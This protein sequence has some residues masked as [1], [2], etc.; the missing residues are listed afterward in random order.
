MKNS[1]PFSRAM[2]AVGLLALTVPLARA[3]RAADEDSIAATTERTEKEVSGNYLQKEIVGIKPQAGFVTFKNSD[4]NTDSRLAMALILE[5]N[6]VSTFY[7]GHKEFK[8]WYIGPSSGLV[9]SHLGEP[10]SN[11]F[12]ADPSGARVAQAGSNFLMIP[13]NLKFG[14]LWPDSNVRFSVRG[15]GNVTYRTVAQSLNFGSATSGGTGPVWR[16]YP[17]I[18]ADIEIGRLSIRPDLTMTPEDEL[19]SATIGYNFSLS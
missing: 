11:F 5:M 3:A 16:M 8:N 17:N 18:G 15:G 7:K 14:Y 4:G 9:F 6:A 19:F 1:I 10:S 2:L 12:G 13:V